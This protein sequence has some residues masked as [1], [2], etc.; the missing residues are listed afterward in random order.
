MGEAFSM[1]TATF[2]STCSRI[3]LNDREFPPALF[4]L[5]L[6]GLVGIAGCSESSNEVPVQGKVTYRGEPLIKGSVTF[7]PASGRPA[8]AAF[9]DGGEYAL[10]LAPGDYTVTVNAGTALPPGFKEGDPTPPPTIV[11]PT[12]FTSRARS[13]LTASVSKGSGAPINFELK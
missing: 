12:E 6:I 7:Y 5:L 2:T 4:L 9:S 10:E 11:L 3:P 8:S 13:K 1:N